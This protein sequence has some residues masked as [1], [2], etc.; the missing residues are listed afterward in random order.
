MLFN[1]EG[2]KQKE[3]QN[4]IIKKQYN[5]NTLNTILRI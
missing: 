5:H 2:Y 4:Y 3:K 1:S